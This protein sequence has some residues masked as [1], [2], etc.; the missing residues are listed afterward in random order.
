VK[1]ALMVLAAGV[2]LIVASGASG[3]G[4]IDTS[5]WPNIP[6]GSQPQGLGVVSAS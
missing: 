4:S 5:I 2:M 6:P 3:A 1:H